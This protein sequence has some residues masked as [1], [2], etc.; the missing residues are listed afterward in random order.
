MLDPQRLTIGVVVTAW[1]QCYLKE[2]RGRGNSLPSDHAMN[3]VTSWFA[4]NEPET[5][6]GLPKIPMRR[7]INQND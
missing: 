6:D 4:T 7:A 2:V 3:M 5:S 1:G